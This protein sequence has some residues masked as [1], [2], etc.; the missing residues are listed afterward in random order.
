[1]ITKPK[2]L[3][4]D[5]KQAI[6][7]NLAPF[8][9]R[10]GFV[11]AVAADGEEALRQVPSLS[12]DLIVLDT[13]MP[14]VG[15]RE[16][17]RR[18]RQADDWTPVILLTQVGEST[19]RAMA[20]DEVADDYINKPFDPHELAAR[21]RAT[22][23]R[24]RPDQPPLAAAHRLACG[25]LSLDRCK[26]RVYVG[27]KE[28]RLTPRAVALLEYVMTYPDEV[29]TRDRLLDAVWGWDCSAGGRTVDTHIAQL[30]RV[31]GD[32]PTQPRYIE[33][34]RGQG[35]RFVGDVRAYR[36]GTVP[37]QAV[38]WSV[39]SLIPSHSHTQRRHM[40]K[41]KM[42]RMT[43]L[44][45]GLLVALAFS[46][47]IAQGQAPEGS[48]APQAEI[49]TAFTYQGR[50]TDASGPVTGTCD[51]TFDL[52]D[53][54]GSG[55]PPTGGTLLGTDSKPGVEVSEGLFTVQLDFGGGVFDGS[56]RW[57]QI[58]V[59][60]GSGA[61]T[62]TPRQELTPAPYALTALALPGLWTQKTAGTPNL[63]GGYWGNSVKAGVEGA[64][65]GGG[66]RRYSTFLCPFV[67][68][69]HCSN[70]VTDNYGTVSGGA[71]NQAGNDNTD[72][73]DAIYATV[74]GGMRNSASGWAATVPGGGDNNA[75]GD[76]SFAAGS[77]AKALHRGT[78]VWA[79]DTN[80]DLASTAANQFLIRA[81]GGVG[82]GTGSPNTILHI[83]G[84]GVDNNG[85]TAVV[86]I[87]SGNG[88]QNLLLDGNEIDAIADGLFL[89]NNTNQKVILARGGGNVGIGTGSPSAKL[90]VAGRTQTNVL[91]ITGGSDLAEPFEIA[92]AENVEPGL[93]V[94][95]DPQHPG[96]LRI[97]DQ[98]YDRTV[99]GCVSGANG[100]NPGLIMQQEGSVADGAS[101]VALSGRVYCWADAAYGAIQPGDLLTTSDTPGHMM[102]VTDYS[103]A[104]GAII[105]K[106]M[107]A[108]TEGQGLILVLVSLQ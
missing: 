44:A 20:L 91:E 14:R 23:C 69:W 82:I 34:V 17:L 1:M 74:G 26:R 28:L 38:D 55:S 62:L 36:I 84:T 43:I 68:G 71:A 86:R 66:G 13:L 15:G 7:A 9:E 22:L 42:T 99:A 80:A 96:Q 81:S 32:D 89:N 92:G 102:R 49:G 33:T 40:M 11:V 75:G 37:D 70:D 95:I 100:L 10:S 16:A 106:A 98:A 6:A 67:G 58:T 77:R 103:K 4:V 12:P 65:I 93:V 31:L 46:L 39:V 30:R 108:L 83:N 64:T 24:A 21:I 56:A 101:P 48:A 50:L 53:E 2:I 107:S 104:Q 97:A 59:N 19:E 73:N 29:L 63:I 51:L 3:V 105:G 57:L 5:D 90:D 35:Y 60:C 94:A 18:L 78:F 61:T 54:A 41:G 47:T 76:F 79:D 8:L 25:D 45:L 27:S 72:V 88:A 87:V 85:S 52:Y